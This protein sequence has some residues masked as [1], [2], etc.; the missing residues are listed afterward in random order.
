MN[1]F[2]DRKTQLARRIEHAERRVDWSSGDSVSDKLL[3]WLGWMLGNPSVP[4][5]VVLIERDGTRRVLEERLPR[6]SMPAIFVALGVGLAVFVDGGLATKLL[7]AGLCLVMAILYDVSARLTER[8]LVFGAS[9]RILR[10]VRGRTTLAEVPFE[11]ID[12][13]YVQVI[14]RESYS[15]IHSAHLVLGPLDLRLTGLICSSDDAKQTA[16]A[17][18]AMTGAPLDPVRR[19]IPE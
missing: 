1:T 5:S 3:C 12:R 18:A 13:V 15:D 10:V 6:W 9:Q 7:V 16:A 14:A 8:H 11:D 17:V 4:E 2:P 19:E